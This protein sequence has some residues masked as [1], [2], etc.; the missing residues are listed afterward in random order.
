MYFYKTYYLLFQCSIVLL[1][2]NPIKDSV[3]GDSISYSQY[4]ADIS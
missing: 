3:F 4:V 2:Y 1:F